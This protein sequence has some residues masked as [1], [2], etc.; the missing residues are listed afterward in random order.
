MML[1]VPYLRF[2]QIKRVPTLFVFILLLLHQLLLFPLFS[3]FVWPLWTLLWLF[4]LFSANVWPLWTL[5]K[6]S[7]R[8]IQALSLGYLTAS[9][10]IELIDEMRLKSAMVKP[11]RN[12]RPQTLAPCAADSAADKPAT[13][14]LPSVRLRTGIEAVRCQLDHVAGSLAE[15]LLKP[16]K[17]F[18]SSCQK[19][20]SKKKTESIRDKV[21]YL[22]FYSESANSIVTFS[23]SLSPSL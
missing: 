6:K 15:P 2:C 20:S 1:Y 19:T 18:Y 16:E 8:H 10:S 7:M 21:E 23:H 3:F 22:E 12:R 5:H 9:M 14:A 13:A 11:P 17:S 4:P